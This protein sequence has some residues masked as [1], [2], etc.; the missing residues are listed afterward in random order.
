MTLAYRAISRRERTVAE[1]R[2][3]LERK[4]IEEADIIGDWRN[5]ACSG[6]SVPFEHHQCTEI[7]GR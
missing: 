6:G 2:A 7:I 1:V 3:F 4:E 5:G